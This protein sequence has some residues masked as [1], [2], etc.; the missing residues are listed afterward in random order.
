MFCKKCGSQNYIKGGF[1]EGEQRYKCKD[2]GCQFVPTRQRGKSESEKLTAVWLYSQGVSYRTIAKFL[3][4]N[5]RSAFIW[6]KTFDQDKYIT[7]QPYS[8]GVIVKLDEMWRYLC[9]KKRRDEY[10]G[11]ILTTPINLSA[12][13]VDG[14]ILTRFQ[15]ST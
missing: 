14:E 5:V 13:N 6:V 15:D 11:L 7:L 2:C 12:E 1:V 9:S 3:E 8:D 4:V 10:G